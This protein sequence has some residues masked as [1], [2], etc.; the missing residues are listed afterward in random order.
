MEYQ[1]LSDEDVT[2][3]ISYL[4]TLPAV[5]YEVPV[6]NFNLLGK[7]ILAF[8]IRPVNPV[9]TP[10]A[11]TM[12]D[13]TAQYG[14]YLARFVSGC[15][16]CHTERNPNTG[17]Y[18]GEEFAGGPVE[19]VKGGP[20]RMLY[21]ANLTTDKTGVLHDWNYEKFK[22]RFSKGPYIKETIMPWNNFKKLNDTELLAIWKYLQT[23]KPVNNDVGAYVQAV[24][25]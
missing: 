15:H 18:I 1:N 16:S 14:E 2:A 17:G 24:K 12:A 22:D 10:P 5:N 9:T 25:K 20:P 23:L 7:S 3:I 8:L 13:T 11:K 21:S 4:R 6:N 19:P